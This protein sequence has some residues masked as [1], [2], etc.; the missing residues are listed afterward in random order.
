MVNKMHPMFSNTFEYYGKVP[1][2]IREALWNY[3]TFGFEP[4]GFTRAVLE[5][6]FII[7]VTTTHSLLPVESLRQLAKWLGQY[8]PYKSFGNK[9]NVKVWLE[10]TN[11]QRRDIMIEKGLR[12]GVFDVLSGR[13]PA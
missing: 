12:P 4:G 6:E 7:A 9:E 10:L 3:F 8:A 13:Q 5:N 11:E 2:E 1:I